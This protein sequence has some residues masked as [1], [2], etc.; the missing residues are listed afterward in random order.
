MKNSQQIY[1]EVLDDRTGALKITKNLGVEDSIDTVYKTYDIAGDIWYRWNNGEKTSRTDDV[2]KAMGNEYPDSVAKTSV[3]VDSMVGSIDELLDEELSKLNRF[4]FMSTLVCSIGLGMG[5]YLKLS[6]KQ[7]DVIGKYFYDKMVTIGGT[8]VDLSHKLTTAKNDEEI[9]SYSKKFYDTR[10]IVMDPFV[11][12]PLI[13]L[14]YDMK[15]KESKDIVEVGRKNRAI[16]TIRKDMDD[17]KDDMKN[18]TSTPLTILKQKGKDIKGY[19]KKMAN[20]YLDELDSFEFEDERL[21]R[22]KNKFYEMSKEEIKKID[23]H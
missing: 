19:A 5:K 7:R 18:G 12:L 22:F 11:T 14:G 4:G 16:G 9:L 20:D 2:R 15:R 17:I 23:Q 3:V 6:D 21:E 13:D 8:E 1:K 10:S